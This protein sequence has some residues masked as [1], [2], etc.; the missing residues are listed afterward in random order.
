[1]RVAVQR[2]IEEAK[3]VKVGMVV[4][5]HEVAQAEAGTDNAATPSNVEE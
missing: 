4:H 5:V 3:E 1:M 2:D